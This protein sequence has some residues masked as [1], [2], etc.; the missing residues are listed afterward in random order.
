M[1]EQIRTLGIDIAKN[2]FQLHGVDEKG[3]VILKKRLSRSQL[4]SFLVN[5]PS[6]LI[7]MEAC[8]GSHYWAREFQKMGHAVKLMSPQFVSPYVKTNKNDY[9]DAEAI[10]EAVTRPNMHFVPIKQTRH[11][12]IQTLHRIRQRLVRQ[13]T[14]LSNEARGLLH[15]YGIIM[16]KGIASLKKRIPEILE[17]AD[18]ELSGMVRGLFDDLYQELQEVEGRISKCEDR[19]NE[20]Y[21]Q[22]EQCQRIGNI[23]GVGHITAT[24][25]IA[26]VADAT[27]FKN[28]RQMA[29]WL[30]LVPRQSSSGGKTVL[31]GI[32]KRGDRYL[33]TLLIHG[34]RSVV[35]R[36]SQKQDKRSLWILDKEKRKGMNKTCVA[37]ANK[38]A[39]IIW[40]LMAHKTEYRKAA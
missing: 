38:N 39:R 21:W 37:V 14:A 20:I 12:D 25:M 29:A 15:E 16:P 8:G 18:N 24:A 27:V 32:S 17:D 9:A 40:A 23:E 1:R 5:L 30:G 4:K 19:I 35:R 33:R 7:G 26:A 34:A 2:V 31:L 3:K 6:C 36:A 22:E 10:A 28:G 11:Q 13:R